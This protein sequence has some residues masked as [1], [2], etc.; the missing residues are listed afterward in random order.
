MLYFFKENIHSSKTD[1]YGERVTTCVVQH[2]D[3]NT[4]PS[5]DPYDE[6]IDDNVTRA[7]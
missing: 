3:M 6:I 4:I 5:I 2:S 1:T 7:R